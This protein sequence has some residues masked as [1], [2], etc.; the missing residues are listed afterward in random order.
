MKKKVVSV[1][2]VAAMTATMVAGCGSKDSNS[3]SGTEG[4]GDDKWS[5]TITVWSPQEDQDTGWLSKECEAFN[6]AHPEW[7]IT[8]K[9]GV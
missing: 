3:A 7:D 5:G 8:F 1:L 2:L 6:E 9:Y 4:S